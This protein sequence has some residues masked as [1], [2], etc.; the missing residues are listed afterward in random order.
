MGRSIVRLLIVVVG[1]GLSSV[2]KCPK[3]STVS[4][5]SQRWLGRCRPKLRSFLSFSYFVFVFSFFAYGQWYFSWYGFSFSVFESSQN[6]IIIHHQSICESLSDSDMTHVTL[7]WPCKRLLCRKL[8]LRH[9]WMDHT[10]NLGRSIIPV[11]VPVTV[12]SRGKKSIQLPTPEI[13]NK[14]ETCAVNTGHLTLPT[15]DYYILKAIICSLLR[16][17]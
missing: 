5:E 8:Y 9:V 11:T 4:I 2:I 14:S 16:V 13:T 7:C 15:D 1:K 12:I 3:P 17:L 10:I 6:N